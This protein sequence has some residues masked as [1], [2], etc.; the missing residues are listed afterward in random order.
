MTIK[1]IR[2]ALQ[3]AA[4]VDGRLTARF[5]GRVVIESL[6]DP[7][8][9]ACGDVTLLKLMQFVDLGNK[10]DWEFF[11]LDEGQQLIRPMIVLS[12]G[13]EITLSKARELATAKA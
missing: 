11:D 6:T 8:A 1:A 5:I 12:D 13:S 2:D 9:G 4:A 7:V 3:V 10:E